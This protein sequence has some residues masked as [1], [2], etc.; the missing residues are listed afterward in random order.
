[1]DHEGEEESGEMFSPNESGEYMS[2]DDMVRFPVQGL[3]DDLTA[4]ECTVT[5]PPHPADEYIMQLVVTM[6][7]WPGR[8]CSPAF[9]WNVGMVLH[10]LKSDPALRELEHVQV[11]GLGLVYLFFYD[12]H[13]CQGL[14]KEAALAICS[15][16]ADTFVE[17][18]GRSAHFEAVPLLLEEECSHA[19][20]AQE[21]CRQHIQTHEQPSLP[22]HAA[23][24]ASSGSS[25]QLVGGAPP[26][27]EGQG[28][29]VE[30]ATPRASAMRLH[31]CPMKARLMPGGGGGNLLPFSLKWP[32]GADSDDYSTA[33][34]PGGGHR[35]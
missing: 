3:R 17:W 20:A 25:L 30:Q 6:V 21:K 29:G 4:A 32:G 22:T 10:V 12:R 18:I 14:T 1:M 15:H 26:I 13:R 31:R 23:G 9:S 8:P 34:E 24:T 27:P 7:D 16:L 35:C 2:H 11:D 19:M 33:S 5:E 28:G